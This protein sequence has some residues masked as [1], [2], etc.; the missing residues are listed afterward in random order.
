MFS[1]NNDVSFHLIL[2]KPTQNP[3]FYLTATQISL[4]PHVQLCIVSPEWLPNS[5]DYKPYKNCVHHF[6][7]W[8]HKAHFSYV[9]PRLTNKNS[10]ILELIILWEVMTSGVTVR[11]S[12]QRNRTTLIW[13]GEKIVL[14]SEIF[15]EILEFK[16][17]TF[18]TWKVICFPML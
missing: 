13:E 3:E 12:L 6:L 11:E 5:F 4:L 7:T 17:Q 18:A 14:S 8:S 16:T 1:L 9:F 2:C 10:K 15:K